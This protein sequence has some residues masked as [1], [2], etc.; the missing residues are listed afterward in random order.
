MQSSI[1]FFK[2][3]LLYFKSIS[4]LFCFVLFCLEKLIFI[5]HSLPYVKTKTIFVFSSQIL[6]Q[7]ITP[8]WVN[9]SHFNESFIL[10]EHVLFYV[11]KGRQKK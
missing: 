5:H 10:E 9:S 4:K 8:A 11:S 1:F 2:P 7:S 6:K 3:V